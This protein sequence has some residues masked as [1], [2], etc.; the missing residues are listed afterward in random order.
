MISDDE[1]KMI[2]CNIIFSCGE[3]VEPLTIREMTEDYF[4]YGD[5]QA[6]QPYYKADR[7]RYWNR[8]QHFVNIAEVQIHFPN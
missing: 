6:V 5:G 4:E 1:L 7:E 8:V 3:D 2:A